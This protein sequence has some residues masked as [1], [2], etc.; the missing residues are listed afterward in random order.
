[1]IA[2]RLR[3]LKR[4][5]RKSV[6]VVDA[7]LASETDIIRL[8]DIVLFVDS[9]LETRNRRARET[10]GWSPEELERRESFQK[11]PEEKKA[12]AHAII[13]NMGNLEE[14]EEQVREFWKREVL[15]RLSGDT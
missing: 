15:S 8:F 10:R 9:D 5:A 3:A 4:K 11:S 2:E 7:A 13:R 6:V 14:T 1:M 12:G